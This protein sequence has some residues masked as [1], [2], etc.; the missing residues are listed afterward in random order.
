MID[1]KQGSI[2]NLYFICFISFLILLIKIFFE[3]GRLF[4]DRLILRNIQIDLLIY[5]LIL[6]VFLVKL[7]IIFFHIWLPKAHVEAPIRG[8]LIL[9]G[10]I[11]KLGGYGV[12][13]LIKIIKRVR[14]IFRENLI[15]YLYIGGIVIRLVCLV[16][17]DLKSLVA[18]RSI[19]H[20][21]RILRG[22]FSIRIYGEVGGMFV[23]IGHGICSSSLFFIV[24]IIYE[25]TLRRNIII[26]KGAIKIFFGVIIWWFLF[27]YCNISG[28]LNLNFMGEVFLLIR[29]YWYENF[30]IILNLLFIFFRV[31]FSLYLFVSIYHGNIYEGIYRVNKI[32]V[33][34]FML[35]IFYWIPLNI[36][37]ILRYLFYLNSLIIEQ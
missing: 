9:A 36:F 32:F 6:F 37:V 1:K 23:M 12:Y 21:A 8:S 7:P 18:Y 31:I 28:P 35:I 10:V 15:C 5:I 14:Y 30:I 27:C 33:R 3:K 20:I 26:N 19:V 34:E 25:R 13:R 22:I 24:N 17:V 2:F 11:L 29:I 16:Q 4:I